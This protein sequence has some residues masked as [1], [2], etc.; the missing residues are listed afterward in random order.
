MSPTRLPASFSRSPVMRAIAVAVSIG[1][2]SGCATTTTPLDP[3]RLVYERTDC[4]ASPDL[5]NAVSLTPRS[6]RAYFY[7]SRAVD[8]ATPCWAPD[9]QAAPYIVFEIPAA[10][11]DKTLIVGGGMEP[12]RIFAARIMTLDAE[13][14]PVREFAAEDFFFRQ[15]LYS[16][17]FRPREWERYILV[18]SDRD[19]VGQTYSSIHIGVNSG[20][21]YAAGTYVSYNIGIDQSADRVFS[22]TGTV[23]VIVQDGQVD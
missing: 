13:G 20:A 4:A 9:A 7:V 19:L 22:H 23:S 6:E 14:A 18:T 2:V 17:Q 8:H 5:M 10:F 11:A 12:H 1:L 16:V 21:T 15:G 3:P